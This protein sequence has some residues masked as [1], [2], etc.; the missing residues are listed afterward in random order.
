M[1]THDHD[2][3]R[4]ARRITGWRAYRRALRR[5]DGYVLALT[6]LLILP[7]LAFTAYAVDLGAWQARGAQLQRA[8]DAAA[9]AAARYMP[10]EDA[11]RTAAVATM[12]RNGFVHG[13]DGITITYAVPS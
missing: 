12:R 11:A 8:A 3:S 6:A 4:R 1:T 10:D 9:L 7:L 5:E 13:Q 2:V